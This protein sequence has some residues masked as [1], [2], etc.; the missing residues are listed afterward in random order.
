MNKPSNNRITLVTRNVPFTTSCTSACAFP[1]MLTT[2]QLYFPASFPATFFNSS[3]P[4][5]TVQGLNCDW[6]FILLHFITG[7]GLPFTE[8]L[9]EADPP[10]L[11]VSILGDTATTGAEIDSPGSPLALGMPAG[12]MSP[13]RPLSSTSPFGPAGPRWPLFPG[14]PRNPFSP[15]GPGGQRGP[16]I[17]IPRCGCET[18][19]FKSGKSLFIFRIVSAMFRYSVLFTMLS[20]LRLFRWR[21][22][23]WRSA[24]AQFIY[25]I[26]VFNCLV[27]R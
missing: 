17:H 11:T 4:P 5:D 9:N 6:L 20:T 8:H 10:S 7:L 12:P 27:V 26:P 1:N 21:A 15:L 23:D 25:K 2:E 3:F 24:K 19:C 14:N 22:V 16:G 18:C 13:F